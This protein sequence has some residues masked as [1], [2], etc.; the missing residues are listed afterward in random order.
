[1]NIPTIDPE[2]IT[3][4]LFGGPHFISMDVASEVLGILRHPKSGRVYMARE[5]SVAWWEGRN[6]REAIYAGPQAGL[7]W[8]LPEWANN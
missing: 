6:A 5:I 3:D 2:R 7:P 4:R 8:Q 1:M